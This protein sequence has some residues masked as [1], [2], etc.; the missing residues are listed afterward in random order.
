[1]TKKINLIVFVESKNRHEW[2]EK[3]ISTL[4]QK[5]FSLSLISLEGYGSQQHYIRKNF[6]KVSVE[7][8]RLKKHGVLTGIYSVLRFRRRHHVN[9]LLAVGHPASYICALVSLLF[10]IK[11]ALIHMQQPRFFELMSTT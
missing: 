9:V 10:R 1:M 6:P 4:D 5:E 7:N 2:L 3:L 8:S 11:F